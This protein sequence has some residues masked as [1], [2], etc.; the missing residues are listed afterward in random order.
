METI[1]I[2]GVMMYIVECGKV[3]LKHIESDGFTKEGL[4]N[5]FLTPFM[6]VIVPLLA[7]GYGL[8]YLGEPLFYTRTDE[9]N[10]SNENIN[11]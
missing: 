8:Y 5:C 7:V 3:M 2:C 9:S 6:P 4:T 11:N 10:E 1:L